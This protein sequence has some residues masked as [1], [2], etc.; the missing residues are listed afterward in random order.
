MGLF[1]K[2][3]FIMGYELWEKAKGCMKINL[4][5]TDNLEGCWTNFLY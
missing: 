4:M 5:A 2:G 1:L 3:Y